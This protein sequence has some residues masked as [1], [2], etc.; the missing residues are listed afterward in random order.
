[1]PEEIFFF[2][3]F[4]FGCTKNV[5]VGKPILA[6]RKRLVFVTISKKILTSEIICEREKIF[7]ISI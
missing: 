6:A 7:T 4:G 3:T 5:P 2:G 1:L